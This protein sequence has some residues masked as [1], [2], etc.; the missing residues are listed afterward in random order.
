MLKLATREGEQL[1]PADED[2]EK[3]KINRRSEDSISN[4]TFSNPYKNYTR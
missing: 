3:N 1:S 2:L 4:A